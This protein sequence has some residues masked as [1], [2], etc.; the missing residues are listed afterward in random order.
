MHRE[1]RFFRTFI[2][3]VEMTLAKTD[4]DVAARYVER[5]VEPSLWPIFE[6]IKAEFGRTMDAVLGLT[7]APSLLAGNPTLKRTLEVRDAYLIPLHWVQVS[8]LA[9]R[10]ASHA[11]DPALERALLLSLNGIATGLRNTG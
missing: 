6:D 1:W 8:L 5:L 3:N 4:L 7:G 9:R 2:S 10:R 11:G